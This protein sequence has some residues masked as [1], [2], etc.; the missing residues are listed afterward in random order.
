MPIQRSFC[1]WANFPPKFI[2][3]NKS[4]FYRLGGARDRLCLRPHESLN[5]VAPPY[6]IATVVPEAPAEAS[7]RVNDMQHS[8]GRAAD[9]GSS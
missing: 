4:V 9:A 2:I 1:S 8:S 6:G 5:P 7:S 3:G